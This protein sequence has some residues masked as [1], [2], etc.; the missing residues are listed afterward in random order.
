[1]LFI[2]NIYSLLFNRE[3]FT[4]NKPLIKLRNILS[5]T[6]RGVLTD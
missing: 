1:L 3:A 4:L 5:S 2:N 6:E